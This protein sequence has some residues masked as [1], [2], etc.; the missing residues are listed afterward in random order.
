MASLWKRE[1][2]KYW[3]ACFTDRTGKQ[4]KRSTGTTDRKE[5][6]K[7]AEEFETS[8]RRRRTARQVRQVMT[9]LHREF[10]SE[11]MP[12]VT[13]RAYLNNWLE[14]KRPETAPA[15]LAFY[16]KTV[17]KFLVFLADKAD[18]SMEE[19]TRDH[20]GQFRNQQAKG[21]ASNTVN[22]ELKC[23]KTIFKAARR[24]GAV[25]EDPTE[26]VDTIRHKAVGE[27]RRPFT[28]PEIQAVL[29]AADEEWRSLIR[30]GLYSLADWNQR[31]QPVRSH[32]PRRRWPRSARSLSLHRHRRQS[33][34][35]S[36]RRHARRD[37]QP[38]A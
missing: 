22:H 35:S 30:C 4:R 21:L 3:T 2:S 17:S 7:I 1:N 23:L 34:R 38:P 16:T 33:G 31:G 28:I 20:I 24:D 18:G 32:R 37:E 15:T 27:K 26:F 19:V 12:V 29:S 5:A 9:D 6:A 11:D 14:R 10:T 36:T 13:L 25:V 8:A